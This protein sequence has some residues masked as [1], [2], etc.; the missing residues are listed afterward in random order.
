[1]MKAKIL[2]KWFMFS[3]MMM[4]LVNSGEAIKTQKELLRV[5]DSESSKVALRALQALRNK[6]KIDLSAAF[7][8]DTPK[9]SHKTQ[10]VI[11][12]L[13]FVFNKKIKKI[14]T[15]YV[16]SLAKFQRELRDEE[17]SVYKRFLDE[18]YKNKKCKY[19][20]DEPSLKGTFENSETSKIM[21]DF[22]IVEEPA[23]Q[24]SP[25]S[26]TLTPFGNEVTRVPS[27][28]YVVPAHVDPDALAAFS[29]FLVLEEGYSPTEGEFITSTVMPAAL[30]AMLSESAETSSLAAMPSTL[31]DLAPALVDMPSTSADM[32]LT[33]EDVSSPSV[34]SIAMDFEGL[35]GTLDEKS[36]KI[37]LQ[38]ILTDYQIPLDKLN[39]N[40]LQ[41][42][43]R[44]WYVVNYLMWILNN[45]KKRVLHKKT[46]LVPD[47][48]RYAFDQ[49]WYE[50]KL[51][52]YESLLAMFSP[53]AS[54]ERSQLASSERSP[55]RRFFRSSTIRK[56]NG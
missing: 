21:S 55:R 31:T 20:Q 51:T 36:A 1:M 54:L 56:R 42:Q 17:L 4:F 8:A 2:M 50:T 27:G 38:A 16:R 24:I 11:D 46:S 13:S 25:S 12:L 9:R 23:A 22:V 45:K 32:S 37:T 5:L 39:F 43:N 28:S 3:L 33:L 44:Y 41:D 47:N 26:S 6:H 35:L 7:P 18:W 29:G 15:V 49:Y 14:D 40:S 19:E 30:A 48:P 34:P 52:K 10:Y 53:P